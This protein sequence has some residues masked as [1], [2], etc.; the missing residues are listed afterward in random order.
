[1]TRHFRHA[2]VGEQEIERAGRIREV[3][4]FERSGRGGCPISGPT[5]DPVDEP[6]DIR[7]IIDYQDV[8]RSTFWML[9]H[10]YHLFTPPSE[11][12]PPGRIPVP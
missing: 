3:K 12:Q 11:Q 9:G 5:H 1:V 4:G 7:L 8:T 2:H 10:I 6:E